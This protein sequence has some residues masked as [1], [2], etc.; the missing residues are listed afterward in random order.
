MTLVFLSDIHGRLPALQQALEA[1]TREA[2]D[3]VVLGGDLLYHGPRNGL[4]EGYDAAGCAPLLNE[5]ADKVVAVRG[6]CDSEVD[7]MLLKF[8]ILGDFAQLVVDGTRFFVTH[9]HRFFGPDLPPLSPGTVV[10]SGH[11]HLPEVRTQ[12]GLTFFNP[13]SVALPK[14][15]HPATYGVWRRAT[16]LELK[17]LDG[18][19]YRPPVL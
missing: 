15:G 18:V 14:G 4:F 10:V 2:A 12:G 8:P 17:T 5:W 16:G 13:G 19:P 11:T 9:G 1:A 6:N 3:L 7:Q